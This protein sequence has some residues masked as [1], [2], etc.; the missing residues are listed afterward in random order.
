MATAGG[1]V[2]GV[3]APVQLRDGKVPADTR[4]RCLLVASSGGHLFQLFQ[5]RDGFADHERHWVTFDTDDAQSLL[6]GDSVTW[7][8]H[9]TNRNI[10]NLLRNVVLAVRELR[11]LRPATIVTTG[12]GVAVP[13]CWV[14]RLMGARI[15]YIE[16]F[17]RVS[18]PSLT[19]KLV[20]PV[21]HEFY[22]QW[23]GMQGHF[24]KARYRG[25][26]V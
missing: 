20:H 7:A 5:L 22:V 14:G 2:R 15:V 13:F 26:L 17:A 1:I 21:A 16:S 9:P 25:A 11:R 19:G 18:E 3:R 6:H 4:L 8:H 24:K 12:A 10:P 23:P